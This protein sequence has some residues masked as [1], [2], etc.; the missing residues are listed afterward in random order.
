MRAERGPAQRDPGRVQEGLDAAGDR[1]RGLQHTETAVSR[2]PVWR[3]N[4]PRTG[5]QA[6]Q[7]TRQEQREQGQPGGPGLRPRVRIHGRKQGRERQHERICCA[8]RFL[9]KSLWCTTSAETKLCLR[10]HRQSKQSV[11]RRCIDGGVLGGVVKV[12]ELGSKPG[13][14]E[15]WTVLLGVR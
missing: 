10:R 14:G 9:E 5:A 8:L 11:Y 15:V 7:E 13:S 2:E 3:P 4:T 6:T 1:I 12:A